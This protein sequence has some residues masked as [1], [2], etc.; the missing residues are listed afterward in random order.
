[1]KIYY[2]WVV[3]SENRLGAKTLIFGVLSLV[4]SQGYSLL[5][6]L[7]RPP[8]DSSHLGK[9]HTLFLFFSGKPSS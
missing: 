5:P 6:A 3:F 8:I 1:M 4:A 2:I 7:P 9:Q